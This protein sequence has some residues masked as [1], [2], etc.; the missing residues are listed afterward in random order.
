[1]ARFS[2][3]THASFHDTSFA[4]KGFR[5]ERCCIPSRV[6]VSV[7][8]R[9]NARISCLCGILAMSVGRPQIL[10]VR[11]ISF[12]ASPHGDATYIIG[13]TRCDP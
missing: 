2:E 6:L 9:R 10:Y 12:T 4:C 8:S 1:M 5:D 7:V 3:L 11:T 13:S